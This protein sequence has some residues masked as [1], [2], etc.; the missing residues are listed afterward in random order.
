[1]A[2]IREWR[3]SFI[4]INR[5]PLDVFSPIPTY[6]SSQGDIFRVSSVCR[7]W[8]RTFFQ[9][10]AL[11]SRLYLTR[12]RTDLYLTTLLERSKGSALDIVATR[13]PATLDPVCAEALA[14]VSPHSQR[15]GS[16]DF[17]HNYWADIQ[18]FSDEVVSGPL[19]LLQTLKIDA[20][21]ER[22][23]PEDPYPGEMISPSLPLFA[24]AVNL[25]EFR[26]R[27]EGL[28]FLDYFIFPNLTALELSAMSR[29]ESLPGSQ[30]LNFLEASPTLRTV[31]IAVD[32]SLEGV[33]PER[34]VILP[35][36]EAFGLSTSENGPGCEVA[37]HVSC[38]STRLTSL[39][40]GQGAQELMHLDISLTS[41]AWDA[42]VYQYM[43]SPVEEVVLEIKIARYPILMM[44]FLAFPS[45]GP[46]VLRLG[47]KNTERDVVCQVLGMRH[48]KMFSQISA[49]IQTHPLLP[50][51]KRLCIQDK[52]ITI[53][54]SSE[55]T[56]IA[57]EVKQLLES[58]GPLD[59]LTLDVSDLRPYLTPFLGF[60]KPRRL[61]KRDAFPLIKELA[62]A[63]PSW[64]PAGQEC[65]VAVVELAKLQHVVGVP[66]ERVIIYMENPPPEMAEWLSP[67]VGEVHCCAKIGEDG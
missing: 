13:D 14:L 27:S 64:V 55:S 62:I 67:W 45:P 65:M 25:K 10:A 2:T 49:A 46:A 42:I 30:L 24:G 57:S 17:A 37:A 9:N 26:L 20:V 1:M 61:S 22:D 31:Q 43:A 16:L 19:P 54:F 12:T 59:A 39:L 18:K 44:S 3:N 23:E 41:V 35:N 66:F 7:H 8:R 15:F 52:N 53:N 5:I 6:L 40:Y 36:L 11:W 60:P 33:S 56:Q 58:V 51:V 34:V 29:R 4:P 21:S 48:V 28:P 63:Q 32:V 50:N 38:S 47:Y